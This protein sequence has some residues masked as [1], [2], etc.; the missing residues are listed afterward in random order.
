MLNKND[1]AAYIDPPGTARGPRA[2]MPEPWESL[3]DYLQKLAGGRDLATAEAG[4]IMGAILAGEATDAQLG[5]F[6][7]LLRMKGEATNEIVGC[8][9][10]IQEQ[11]PPIDLGVRPE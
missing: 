6:M 11:Y 2:V 1:G 8:A 3:R 9:T 10:R 4:A 7:T 5:A